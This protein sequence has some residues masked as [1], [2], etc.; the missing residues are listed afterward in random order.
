MSRVENG[1][2]QK[3]QI[4]LPN[5]SCAETGVKSNLIPYHAAVNLCHPSAHGLS[6][7]P[8]IEGHRK[9]NAAEKLLYS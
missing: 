5:L 3:L 9:V 1:N 7:V 8:V 4:F 2:R 6:S